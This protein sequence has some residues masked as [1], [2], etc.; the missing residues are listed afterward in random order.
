[1]L[2]LYASAKCVRHPAQSMADNPVAIVPHILCGGSGTRLWPLSREAFPKQ[3]VPLINGRSLLTCTLERASLLGKRLVCIA[4]AEHRFLVEDAAGEVKVTVEQILEPVGRNTAAAMA[5][6]AML[7]DPEELLLFLPADHY[8]PDAEAFRKSI[9][10][11]VAAAAAGYIVTFGVTPSFPSTA[12]GYI[13]QGKPLSACDGRAVERFIEKPDHE[14][15]RQ[16]VLEGGHFWNAGIFLVRASLLIAALREHAPDIL[17]RCI[18]ATDNASA[19]FGHKL[20]NQ[21]ALKEC[22]ST[23][24]DYAVLEKHR[25]VAMLPFDSAWSDVGSWNAVAQLHQPDPS[26]NRL[27]GQAHAL[28]C[29][30]VFISAPHRPVVALHVKDTIVIDTPDA[31]LVVNA[32]QSEQVREVVEKLRQS[33]SSQ[34]VQHRRTSRPWGA[35]DCVD[36]GERF[37][38]KRLTVKPGAKLSLQKHQ[39]RAEHWVVVTGTAKVTRGEEIFLLTENQSTYIPVG[40]VHRLENPANVPLEMIEVQS[41]GYLG[42]DDIVRFDDTYGRK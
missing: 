35:Y 41:G 34:I 10:K 9:R 19:L 30:N 5:C 17:E 37:Q 14:K 28:H 22:R 15:A 32:N 21:S 4:N 33:G 29:E 3:F 2:L 26:G 27:T 39:H 18:E 16:L 40:M 12:Y 13:K 6:A 24:I 25:Q 8:I 23:S 31:L 38:V 20:L 42:E 1:V 11:G 36:A 7:A